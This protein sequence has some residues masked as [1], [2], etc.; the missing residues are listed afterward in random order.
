MEQLWNKM[1]VRNVLGKSFEV[2]I[3]R[4]Q[5]SRYAWG[6]KFWTLSCSQCP[7]CIGREEAMR[8][9]EKTIASK[10]RSR[11]APPAEEQIMGLCVWGRWTQILVLRD[12][13]PKRCQFFWQKPSRE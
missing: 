4:P 3:E 11:W 5:A 12:G 6:D 13:S 9:I 2:R 1:E 10:G 7:R 8:I